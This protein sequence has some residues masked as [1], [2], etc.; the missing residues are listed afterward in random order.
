M[1][2]HVETEVMDCGHFR[3]LQIF[4]YYSIFF[5]EIKIDEI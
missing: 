1:T 3:K 2:G 4:T 5:V